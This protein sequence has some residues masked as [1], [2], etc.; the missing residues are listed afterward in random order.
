MNRKQKWISL[1][2][3]CVATVAAIAVVTAS[4]PMSMNTPLY[5]LRMEKA[6]SKMNFLPKTAE[7]YSYDAKNGH[8]LTYKDNYAFYDEKLLS[9]YRCDTWCTCMVG[10]TC[11]WTCDY[12]CYTCV[13][14][15]WNTC[16]NTC[17]TCVETCSTCVST[18]SETCVDTCSTCV[19]TCGETCI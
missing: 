6:S 2:V 18:C 8:N 5:T 13:N 10:E 16:V 4:S 17:H 3:V 7:I 1:A 12:T 9:T 19:E 14:T 11:E 15:C